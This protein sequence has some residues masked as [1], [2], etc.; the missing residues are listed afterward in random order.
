MLTIPDDLHYSEDHE[1]IR[2]EGSVAT[3]GLTQYAIDSLGEVVF[4]DPPAP[5]RQINA[6][7]TCGEIESTKAVG[8]ITSPATGEVTEVNQGLVD[9]PT[10]INAE[11][12]GSGWIYR[13]K[14]AA[15]P[16]GLMDAAEYRAHIE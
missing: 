15:Q 8:D 11:P 3:I 2:I 9:D 16:E 5:G 1:W 12:Y 7:Q 4:I 6:G 13:M 14:L 10:A